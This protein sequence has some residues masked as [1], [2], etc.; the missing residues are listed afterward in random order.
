M[1]NSTHPVQNLIKLINPKVKPN[2]FATTVVEL[3][4]NEFIDNDDKFGLFRQT[5]DPYQFMSIESQ[6]T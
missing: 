5:E 3:G 1:S 4:I 2:I 6:D